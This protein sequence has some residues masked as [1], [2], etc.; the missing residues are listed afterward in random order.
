LLTWAQADVAANGA[1]D[2]A[3]LPAPNTSV[4]TDALAEIGALTE[5]LRAQSILQN[6]TVTVAEAGLDD[7]AR[8]ALVLARPDTPTYVSTLAALVARDTGRPVQVLGPDG[9]THRFG[10]ADGTP[11]TLYFDGNRFSVT[12]PAPDD[13]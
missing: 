10:P 9:R 8:L 11:L 4:R 12:P 13:D 2:D 5:E 3:A 6:G 7:V 1:P